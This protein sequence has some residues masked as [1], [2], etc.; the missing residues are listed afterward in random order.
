MY[1][2]EIFSFYYKCRIYFADCRCFLHACIYYNLAVCIFMQFQ[3][4]GC[5]LFMLCYGE[6]PFEDSA[7]L[8]IINGKYTI[9]ESDTQYTVFHDL[10]SESLVFK[11][12]IEIDVNVHVVHGRLESHILLNK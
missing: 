8:R 2:W 6:H 11:Q 12:V 7:K 3:A 10:L 9:P 4:L 1:R 5:V